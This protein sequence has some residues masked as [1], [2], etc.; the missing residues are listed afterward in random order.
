MNKKESQIHKRIVFKKKKSAIFEKARTEFAGQE[1]QRNRLLPRA[2]PG[3]ASAC[4][5]GA[6]RGAGLSQP[7]RC[8]TTLAPTRQSPPAADPPGSDPSLPLI[9]HLSS[10]TLTGGR[11]VCPRAPLR[12]SGRC[13]CIPG[14]RTEASC[15]HR[16]R[17]SW[18]VGQLRKPSHRSRRSENPAVQ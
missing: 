9:V 12:G 18:G 5:P 8:I 13:Y 11:R 16:A 14:P 2:E 7:G 17:P 6:G 15:L 1:Q 3:G 10:S 4:L